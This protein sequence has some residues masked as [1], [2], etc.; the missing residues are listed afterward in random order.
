[1]LHAVLNN[2]SPE[3]FRHHD[4]FLPQ[5]LDA[6]RG[7]S[8]AERGAFLEDPPAGAPSLEQAHASAASEGQTEAPA[9]GEEVDLHFVAFV[10]VGGKL[11]ELD[12]RKERPVP[13]GDSSPETLLKDAVQVVRAFIN[14]S[15]SQQ[16]NLIAL[17][18]PSG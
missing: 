13:H 2:T 7:M 8:P 1:M 18:P 5:F 4:T 9:A 16:F 11:Y 14:E 15:D 17:A 6:T 3:P 12:G 10:T